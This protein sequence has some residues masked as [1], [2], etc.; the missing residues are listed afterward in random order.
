MD[1]P[2]LSNTGGINNE[3]IINTS[4]KVPQ[5]EGKTFVLLT[6]KLKIRL[7]CGKLQRYLRF[8][9]LCEAPIFLVDDYD[10]ISLFAPP[11][12]E[13]ISMELNGSITKSRV[14]MKI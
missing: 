11:L 10:D 7:T 1:S 8:S 9:K 5:I 12:F 2:N 6:H 13:F 14:H 4:P 3:P